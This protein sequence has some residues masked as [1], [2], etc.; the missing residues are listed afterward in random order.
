MASHRR[1]RVPRR[2]FRS[3]DER[4]SNL[5]KIDVSARVWIFN[6]FG[7]RSTPE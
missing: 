1:F 3:A 4:K 5:V 6:Q 2:P 7:L